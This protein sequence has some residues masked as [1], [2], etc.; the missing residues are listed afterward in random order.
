MRDLIHYEL[1]FGQLGVKIQ[2][3]LEMLHISDDSSDPI[4]NEVEQIF[5]QLPQICNI[6]GDIVI[7][8]HVEVLHKEGKIRTD[9]FEI[10]PRQRICTYMKDI[11]RI[12]A[13]ICTA[14]EKFTSLAR[15]LNNSSNFLA[16]FIVDT[17]GSIIVEKSM[18]YIQGQLQA[19]IQRAGLLITNRYSPGYCLWPLAGQRELFNLFPENK[20]GITLTE[21]CLM[22][23]MK[24]V[25][26]IIGIGRDVKKLRYK[27]DI[28]NDFTCV[29]RNI[30][31]RNI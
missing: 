26:G 20:S 18:D 12:A 1:D 16:G 8:D 17:F 25:S 15:Q 2:D 24:S 28:C 22:T 23:P 14:G 30:K 7:Y 5:G 6:R 3:A 11:E 13:F 27:C 19:D 21:S 4:Y 9:A 10:E 31:Q 29:Y